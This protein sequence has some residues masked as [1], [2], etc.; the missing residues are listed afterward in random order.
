MFF[1]IKIFSKTP[2]SKN[3]YRIEISQNIRL[4]LNI[5]SICFC[6]IIL[7]QYINKMNSP[8]IMFLLY[9]NQPADFKYKSLDLCLHDTSFSWTSFWTNYNFFCNLIFWTSANS[10]QTTIEVL[11]E[12]HSPVRSLR[13]TLHARLTAIMK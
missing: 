7:V 8:W 10:L 13:H 2:S 12:K 9:R 11:V 6:C 5:L 4:N 1:N 3:L